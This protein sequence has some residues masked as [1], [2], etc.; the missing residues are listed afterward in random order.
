MFYQE[1]TQGVRSETV[2]SF[3]TNEHVRI[4]K[5]SMTI[6]RDPLDDYEPGKYLKSVRPVSGNTQ[7]ANFSF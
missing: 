1:E 5:N 6:A 3:K 4:K 2:G 7:F